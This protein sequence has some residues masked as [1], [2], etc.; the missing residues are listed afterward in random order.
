MNIFKS[1]KLKKVCILSI[2]IFTLIVVFSA[3]SAWFAS[4]RTTSTDGT[5][6][7]TTKEPSVIESLE[8]HPEIKDSENNITN[9]SYQETATS[10]YNPQTKTWSGDTTNEKFQLGTYSSL[11]PIHSTLLLLKIKE[12][13]SSCKFKITTTTDYTSSLVGI[14]TTN[15][16]TKEIATSGNPFSSI[17]RFSYFEYDSKPSFDFTSTTLD[18]KKAFYTIPS[19][20]FIKEDN[21]QKELTFTDE[22]VKSTTTYIAIIMEYYDEGIQYIYSLNLGASALENDANITYSADWKIEL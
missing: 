19:T 21:Y 18:S 20:G 11:S 9:Y 13:S 5:G 7:I 4:I 1:E 6:F 12:G 15:K 22:N 10:T 2:S 8:I 17:L 14:D 3:T 16:P